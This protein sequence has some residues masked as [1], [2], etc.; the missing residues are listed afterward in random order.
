[1]PPRVVAS[2]CRGVDALWVMDTVWSR[3]A[4]GTSPMELLQKYIL[5][6]EQV[7]FPVSPLVL[8]VKLKS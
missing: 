6:S 1:M 7:T 3:R 8:V 5:M 4:L 2:M